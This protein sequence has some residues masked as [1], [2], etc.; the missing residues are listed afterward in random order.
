MKT[1]TPVVPPTP[2]TTVTPVTPVATETPVA[3]A[4]DMSKI[5]T[6]NAAAQLAAKNI[7]QDQYDKV[8]NTTVAPVTQTSTETQPPVQ[9]VKPT[10][11]AT[12]TTNQQ[13]IVSKYASLDELKSSP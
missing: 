5:N 11:R 9:P 13:A 8:M 3:P 4:V 12:D 6:K 7:S 2:V 10:K 1:A